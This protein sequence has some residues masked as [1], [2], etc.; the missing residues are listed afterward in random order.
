[1]PIF[2]KSLSFE[3]LIYWASPSSKR[4]GIVTDD[5]VQRRSVSRKN[6]QL[7]ER[8]PFCGL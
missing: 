5:K 4:E 2:L 1:L 8:N 7:E 3:K 6:R